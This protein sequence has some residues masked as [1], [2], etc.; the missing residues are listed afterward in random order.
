V[1][2]ADDVR[3]ISDN[4]CCSGGVRA[5]DFVV[6]SAKLCKS[7][8]VFGKLVV[9]ILYPWMLAYCLCGHHDQIWVLTQT[10]LLTVS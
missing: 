8:R 4:I 7:F 1:E 5:K 6:F 9:N 10:V 3:V 2:L